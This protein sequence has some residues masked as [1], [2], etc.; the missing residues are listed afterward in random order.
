[1]KYQT[2]ESIIIKQMDFKESD[3]IITFLTKDQGKRSGILRGVKKI[4]S[5][6]AGAS[7]PFTY[8]QIHYVEKANTEL[9]Q[10]RK[11]D[12]IDHFY[13][14]RQVYD[15]ILYATY[16]TELIHLCM[17]DPQ[18][19][20]LYFDL[21]LIALQTLQHTNSC[22]QV[23]I[24]F[25]KDLLLILGILPNLEQCIQC[26][27]SLWESGSQALPKLKR[28]DSH[29]M[30]YGAGGLRCS[31]CLVQTPTTVPLSP[32]T[33]SYL[34]YLEKQTKT[35]NNKVHPTQQNIRELDGLFLNYFRYHLGKAP[36]SHT[37]LHSLC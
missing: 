18:E 19:S 22:V 8:G 35:A 24:Q 20:H 33:I 14:I 17:V 32:G 7:E 34:R 27:Q 11:F 29:Q 10:I 6:H 9:V 25:E 31:D 23:K 4:K 21:L 12:P 5:K 28:F 37:L 15:K 1:M 30:D 36:K 13:S 26:H 2:T 3:Q 16:L